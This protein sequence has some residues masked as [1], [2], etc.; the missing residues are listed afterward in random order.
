MIQD[1]Y[2]HDF[3]MPLIDCPLCPN[4]MHYALY[5]IFIL[6]NIQIDHFLM[7]LCT[8]M[9]RLEDHQYHLVTHILYCRKVELMHCRCRYVVST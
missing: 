2:S 5:A 8:L 6:Y 3:M 1:Y 4:I 9:M 7:Y